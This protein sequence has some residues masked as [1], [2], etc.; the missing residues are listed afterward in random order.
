MVGLCSL[1]KGFLMSSE[2]AISVKNISKRFEMYSNPKHRLYQMLSFGRRTFF[3]EFWAL[4]GVSFDVKRG[5][6]L[7]ILGRNGEG[8]STLLQIIAG[9]LTPTS[10][11]VEVNGKLAA[12][13]ELGAGFN[14]EFTGRENV[15]LSGIILGMTHN[16]MEKKFP[17][18]EAFAD[19]GDHIDQPVKTYSSGMYVRLAFAVQACIKPEVL[20]IDEALSVGDEKFQRKCFDY[21]ESLRAEGCSIILVTHSTSTVEK[22]CQRAILL[23]KG[24]V[25]SIGTSKEIIDQYHA[26]LYSDEKTYL[27]YLNSMAKNTSATA[28]A[29]TKAQTDNNTVIVQ[30]GTEKNSNSS[31]NTPV[32]G[33]LIES[34][35]ITDIKGQPCDLFRVGEKAI[36][37]FEVIVFGPIEELQAGLVI[38]T[39]EGITVFGTSTLYHKKNIYNAKG[40][41]IIKATFELELALCEGSY[42]ISLAL[43]NSISHADMSYLDKKTDIIVLKIIEPKT[44]M[45]GIAALPFSLSLEKRSV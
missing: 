29:L 15:Y 37:S 27:R 35:A 43:A 5:E 44:T 11:E 38:K 42:F 2:F 41:D 7:G 39:V 21:I 23:R 19:I 45:S 22:F 4:N 6:T 26:L 12:L 9:T 28:D 34:W 20:I 25:E 10:G 36:I 13:L 40:G 16:E 8:K 14:P 17:E 32:S 1:V 30:H 33:A 24:R 18:I 3:K 31:E